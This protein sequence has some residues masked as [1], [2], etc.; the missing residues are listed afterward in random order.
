MLARQLDALV[1]A[2]READVPE[3]SDA[4]VDFEGL[5]VSEDADGF[6]FETPESSAS[7]LSADDLREVADGSPYVSNWYVWEWEVQRHDSPRRAFCR[8]LEAA[9][10]MAVP[11]RYAALDEG[12]VTE[13]GQLHVE[14]TLGENG[15]RRYALRHVADADAAD[16]EIHREPLDARRIANFDENDR[17]RPLKTAPSLRT[18]WAFPDLDW[19]DLTTAVETFY[20]ATVANWYREREGNLDVDHWVDATARQTGIY[21]VIQTWNRGEGHEHVD[22]VAEACCDDSQCLKRREWQYDDETDLDV[23]GGDG[24]FPCREP[25]SLVI[26]ASRQW[27]KLEGE[28]P[29]TYEFELTPSEK[30]Q[31]E[32]VVDAV[33]EG[34]VGD[35][36]EADVY[37]GA[38]RYRARFLRAKRFDD[39]GNFCGVPTEPDGD[40]GRTDDGGDGGRKDGGD[41]ESGS[42]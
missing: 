13:W 15:R 31:V 41:D 25:C 26:S 33:A 17:Y 35:I 40:D 29:R 19:R 6:T 24:A 16:L 27:T 37:D 28:E 23:D 36:R 10:E 32:D 4:G 12:M 34:R 14:A 3:G 9:D 11:E 22:W 5:R 2:A 8:K 18:G 39:D 7:G 1:A 30:E 42:D 20:P 21:G 38:N